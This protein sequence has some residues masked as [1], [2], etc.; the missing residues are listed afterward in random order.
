V[1]DEAVARIIA[2]SITNARYDPH[3]A[4]LVDA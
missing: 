1:I 2:G 4:R 3:T